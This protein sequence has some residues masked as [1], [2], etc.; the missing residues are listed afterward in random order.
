MRQ[1]F[2]GKLPAATHQRAFFVDSDQKI[3][4]ETLVNKLQ[5]DDGDENK[6]DDNP[7]CIASGAT[8]GNGVPNTT[9]CSMHSMD[10]DFKDSSLL[11]M[12]AASWGHI[13]HNTMRWKCSAL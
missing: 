4:H 10:S 9:N 2:P 12:H 11:Q 6:G 13:H 7:D 3:T 1:A 5:E 8:C